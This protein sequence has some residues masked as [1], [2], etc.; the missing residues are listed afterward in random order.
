MQRP[1]HPNRKK[2][3]R[4]QDTRERLTATLTLIAAKDCPAEIW[5][6]IFSL[7]CVDGGYT[8]RSLSRVSKYIQQVSMP[9]KYQ[10]LRVPERQLRRLISTL[11]KMPADARCVRHLFVSSGKWEKGEVDKNK[12][13][14][15]N[16][17]RLLSLI[18]PSL[19]TLYIGSGPVNLTLPFPLPALVDLVVLCEPF[20][21]CSHYTHSVNNMASCYPILRRLYIG[22]HLYDEVPKFINAL[23][24]TVKTLRI[25]ASYLRSISCLRSALGLSQSEVSSPSTLDRILYENASPT[26]R[27]PFRELAKREPRFV[28]VKERYCGP[29]YF[30]IRLD[31]AE[32]DKRKWLDVCA[33]QKD[34]WE[35]ADE[36]KDSKA[37][38]NMHE[39]GI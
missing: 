8:G 21:T 6:R 19:R 31:A 1:C 22:Y 20:G 17:N 23:P 16:R 35:P 14:E 10:T 34:Y 33:G 3:G 36:E 15:G 28:L 27:N 4:A 37:P 7:A 30:N 29:W 24:P 12:F 32:E 11:N 5:S 13:F 38:Y 26:I 25:G 2:R 18:A 39:L 9:Y